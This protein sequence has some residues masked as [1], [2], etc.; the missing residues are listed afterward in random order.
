[1]TN[2]SQQTYYDDLTTEG[3]LYFWYRAFSFIQY[4]GLPEDGN[5]VPKHVGTDT[6]HLFYFMV[7]MLLNFM[8]RIFR[9]I[10]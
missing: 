10:Y 7:C 6:Y 8:E 4:T 5:P 9:F 3:I 1:M 2:P